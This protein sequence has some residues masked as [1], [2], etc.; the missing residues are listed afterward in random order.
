MIDFIRVRADRCDAGKAAAVFLMFDQ[1]TE[2]LCEDLGLEIWFPPAKLRQRC[3]NKVEA[4]RIG[5]KAG[6]PSVPNV[7]ARVQNY[8]KLRAVATRPDLGKD[9]VVQ[10]PTATRAHHL[11]HLV[12]RRTGT[13]TP[14]SSRASAR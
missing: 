12:A 7:L 4:V 1:R 9:L 2:E 6:V 3:D 5:E 14:R 10:T 8:Q 13:R 11:L